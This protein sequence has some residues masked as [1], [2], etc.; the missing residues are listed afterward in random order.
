MKIKYST[1]LLQIIIGI[2]SILPLTVFAESHPSVGDPILVCRGQ[3]DDFLI[4]FQSVTK[5]CGEWRAGELPDKDKKM[6]PKQVSGTYTNDNYGIS[7][8]LPDG[9]SGTVTEFH[10]SKVGE[11]I[12]GLQAMEGGIEENMDAMQE[13]K[14]AIIMFT[15]SDITDETI[16][17]EPK[18]P[19]EDYKGE[20]GY[21][22]AEKIISK[23][24]KAMKLD[25]ECTGDDQS[26]MMR[27]YHYA[28]I[29]KVLMY[30]YAT[31]PSSDF[32]NNLDKFEDSVKTLSIDNLVDIA[33]EIPD[34]LMDDLETIDDDFDDKVMIED[35][36]TIDEDFDDKEMMQEIIMSPRKQ[37]EAGTTPTDVVCNDGKELLIKVSTGSGTCVKSSSVSKLIER[38]WGTLS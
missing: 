7:I 31:S 25:A 12:T 23:G 20:C 24:K 33:Y 36:E 15:I 22:F 37:I 34:E 29:D 30:A 4:T 1:L 19:N 18:S 17:P 9:W 11:P 14:F 35:F 5:T 10:V 16:P 38:G 27:A 13:G 8:D 3:S 28:T 26:M 21:I 32:E 2:L 6:I